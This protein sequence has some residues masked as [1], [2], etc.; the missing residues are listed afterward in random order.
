M[1]SKNKSLS[2]AVEI[3]DQEIEGVIRKI[4]LKS[5]QPSKGQ[6]R[7]NKDINI[8]TL[9][10]SLE[11]DGLLQ[12]ILVTREKG[13]YMII[14]GE[15]RYRAAMS[16][17]WPDIECR[18]LNKDEKES[19]KLAVVENLQRENLDPLEESLAYKKLKQQFECSDSELS[20]IV[21]KSRNYI[22]EILSIAEIPQTLLEKA[23]EEGITSKNILIQFAQSVKKGISD[24]FI[25]QFQSGKISTVKSAK[26]YM[27]QA[28]QE[29]LEELPSDSNQSEFSPQ[30]ILNQE[31]RS[32]TKEKKQEEAEDLSILIQKNY[33]KNILEITIKTPPLKLDYMSIPTIKKAIEKSI[34][35]II[36]SQNRRYP[37]K[38]D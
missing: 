21:G 1:V 13:N 28:S 12:P 35:P 26:K 32:E 25:D 33:Q 29:H 6:P 20:R 36:N 7:Q 22:S 37:Q 27:H 3:F 38:H 2:A 34:S 23:R 11:K 24:N 10:N 15:R 17:N 18:I 19:Y 30:T 8:Q 5:I 16:L 9:A 14:A 4:P 31:E